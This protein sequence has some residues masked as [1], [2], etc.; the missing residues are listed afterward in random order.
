MNCQEVELFVSALHDG[1]IVPKEAAE[2]IASCLACKERLREYAQMSA[3]LRLLASAGPEEIPA[4]L[5]ALPP[6]VRRWAHPLTARV[7]V[8]RFALGLGVLLIAALSLSLGVMRAQVTGLWFQFNVTSPGW[9]GSWGNEVQAGYRGAPGLMS[10]VKL[11]GGPKEQLAAIINVD[12]VQYGRV[13]LS[14]RARRLE[15]ALGGQEARQIPESV[16]VTPAADR[17]ARQMLANIPP[18]QYEYIPGQ[19]LEIP[20]EG[21]GK[22]LLT[23]RV[24]ERH[25]RFWVRGNFPLEPKPDQIVLNEPALVRD[26]ELLVKGAGSASAGGDDPYVAM[27]V[28]KEGLFAFLLKPIDGAVQAEAEYGQAGFKLGGH[29]YV[30]FSATPITGGQQPREIWIYHDPNYQASAPGAIDSI[31]S[32]TNLLSRLRRAQK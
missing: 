6:P 30:L 24:L 23:G 16:E 14:V 5:P 26:K 32:G 2:H 29:D 20:V 28:P 17:T 13:R 11:S 18:H 21:G 9:G 12:E 19:V 25:A 10:R 27:F 22:L 3:E 8:P 15:V 31:G 1:E 7:L 4:L